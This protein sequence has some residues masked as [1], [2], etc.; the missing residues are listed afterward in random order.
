[1]KKQTFILIILGM[2][3]LLWLCIFRVNAQT[4]TL[5]PSGTTWRSTIDSITATGT[6]GTI[7]SS[8]WVKTTKKSG[9]TTNGGFTI[10]ATFTPSTTTRDSYLVMK[11]GTL[12]LRM[13]TLLR[14]DGL[15]FP[16]DSIPGTKTTY[17]GFSTSSNGDITIPKGKSVKVKFTFDQ[18]TGIISTYID[19]NLDRRMLWT[20]PG[21]PCSNKNTSFEFFRGMNGTK[22]TSI[23]YK[24]GKPSGTKGYEVEVKPDSIVFTRNDYGAIS[25]RII[26]KGVP[27]G[28]MCI[29]FT[30][31]TARKAYW[32]PRFSGAYNTVRVVSK[33][34]DG[35]WVK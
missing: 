21:Q 31:G 13:D 6:T 7:S 16:S 17:S 23:T 10:E 19:D 24:S 1:M 34:K 5:T 9:F 33:I 25:G 26:V 18:E 22:V 29:P 11:S 32:I 20:T 8:L 35:D 2:I 27:E 3:A 12:V 28:R 15:Y 4:F 30:I 14:L